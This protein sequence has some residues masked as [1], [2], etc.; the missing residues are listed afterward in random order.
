MGEEWDRIFQTKKVPVASQTVHPTLG[1]LFTPQSLPFS[2]QSGGT[3]TNAWSVEGLRTGE[4]DLP[5]WCRLGRRQAG[6]EGCV[7]GAGGGGGRLTA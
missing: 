7:G 2:I 4:R 3:K 6:W 1:E 5:V